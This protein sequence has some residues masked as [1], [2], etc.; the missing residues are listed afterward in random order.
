MDLGF[1]YAVFFL[2]IQDL[3][4]GQDILIIYSMN[5]DLIAPRSG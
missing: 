1:L 5:Y 4:G 3:S 2:D